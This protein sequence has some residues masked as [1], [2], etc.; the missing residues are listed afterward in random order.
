M[1]DA[2]EAILERIR[3]GLT[4]GTDRGSDPI[5][6]FAA[7]SR[8]YIR[9]GRLDS[10]ARLRLLIDRLHDYDANVVETTA[11][12]L[13]QTISAILNQ[14]EQKKVIAADGIPSEIFPQDFEFLPE[15]ETGTDELNECDGIVTLCTVAIASTG[16]IVL[17]HGPSEGARRVTLLPDRHLCVVRAEQ[18]V[19]TVPE[20]FDRLAPFATRPL[21]FISGPSATADIEMTRIRGVHGPRILDVVLVR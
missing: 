2:R 14:H 4:A 5:I 17:T 11:D 15:R 8:G 18:V 20:A 1:S 21:T 19:E 12:S 10:D 3:A 7:I 13:S 16:T 9:E 6:E